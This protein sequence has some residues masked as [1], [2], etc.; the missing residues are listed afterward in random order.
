MRFRPS[1]ARTFLL[2]LGVAVATTAC[3]QYSISNIRAL[4]AFKQAN[5]AYSKS[6]YRGA[7][8]LYQKTFELNPDFMGVTYFLIGNSYD[9]LYKPAKKGDPQNDENLVKAV[10]NYK[11]AIEKIKDTDPEG[12]KYRRWAYEWLVAA[13]G[14]DKLD[15]VAQAEPIIQE[16]IKIDPNDA[17]NYLAMA[18]LYEGAGKLEEAEAQ[19]KKA[20]DVRPNDALGYESIAGFYNRVG[21]FEDTM[22]AFN[23]RAS[24]EPN[25]PEAWHTIGTYYEDKI[26]QESKQKPLRVRE[27]V[28]REYALKGIEAEDKALAINPDY[29][30]AVAYKN[31]LLRMQANYE[32]DLALRTRLIKDADTLLERYNELK[33]AQ[34][35]ASD[36]AKKGSGGG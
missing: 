18:K 20:I 35:S 19:F 3:G 27:S 30:E 22:A 25:N 21:R 6:D 28:L 17:G 31:I 11:L 8:E 16:M 32:R 33:A 13:Y 5:E 36:E 14:A 9:M 4:R 24:L 10:E 23:Q 7:I 34:S 1:V 12:P 2:A 29:A 26:F 15:D